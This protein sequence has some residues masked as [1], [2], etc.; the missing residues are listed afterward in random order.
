MGACKTKCIQADLG[1]S[2]YIPAYSRMH[3]KTYSGIVRLFKNL[4]RHILQSH[5]KL[6]KQYQEIKQN[7]TG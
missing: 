1:I 3:I 6:M 7:C 2:M 4:F 5:I